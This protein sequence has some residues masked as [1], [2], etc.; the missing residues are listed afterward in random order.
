MS[1]YTEWLDNFRVWCSDLPDEEKLE[2]LENRLNE[3][4]V[5]QAYMDAYNE[6]DI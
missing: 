5:T 3:K 6:R 1:E 2:I 4:N